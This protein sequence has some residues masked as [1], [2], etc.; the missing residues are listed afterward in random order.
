MS[1]SARPGRA[2]KIRIA[3]CADLF[4]ALRSASS[5]LRLFV[6]K[7][8]VDNPQK[9]LS[10]G[11]FQG[12]E[13]CDEAVT[14]WQL[15]GI[16]TDER[17][18]ALAAVI[19]L[20]ADK[21]IDLCRSDFAC[22]G[23]RDV[24]RVAASR[25]ASEPPERV[26]GLLRRFLFDDRLPVRTRLAATLMSRFSSLSPRERLRTAIISMDEGACDPPLP[27][28]DTD[29]H[30]IDEL[31]G[32][33]AEEARALAEGMGEGAFRGLARIADALPEDG[34]QWLIEWGMRDHPLHAAGLAA[35]SLRSGNEKTV[36][37]ALRS[38]Q[39][40]PQ[41]AL[42]QP[43]LN[44]LAARGT[45]D[46]RAAAIDAG[47]VADRSLIRTML[48]SE[49]DGVRLA[50]IRSIGR[51]KD[52][53]FAR[54]LAELFRD[55]DWRIRAAASEAL[56]QMGGSIIEVLKP[57]LD[58][59]GEQVKLAAMNTLFALGDES[60]VAEHMKGKRNGP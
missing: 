54:E 10:Y 6:L 5:S 38:I 19:A 49:P 18:I 11:P 40:S 39:K 56:A 41:A 35:D 14:R 45:P 17:A 27:G 22:S 44:D 15:S 48:V 31:K 33:W 25:L 59:C 20:G 24:L 4:G 37:A 50:L 53:E 60:L 42:F 52:R 55:E 3:S 51:S 23:N 21:A 32:I 26:E 46:V 28:P 36:L 34:K 58:D 29:R 8:I 16:D 1:G 13:L 12:R 7:A 43:L 30:W 2:Q 57:L 9:A 47:G